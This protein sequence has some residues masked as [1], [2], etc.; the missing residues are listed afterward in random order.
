M[1]KGSADLEKSPEKRWFK[2]IDIAHMN[3]ILFPGRLTKEN[4]GQVLDK[5]WVAC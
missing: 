2:G 4:V 1:V 5:E 3:M